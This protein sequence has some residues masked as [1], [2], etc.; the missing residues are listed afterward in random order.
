MK[1]VK[2]DKVPK[3]VFINPIFTGREVTRQV[4]LPESAYSSDFGQSFLLIPDAC[5]GP[6]RTL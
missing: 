6:N 1:V 3:E 4:L 2:M 5:S